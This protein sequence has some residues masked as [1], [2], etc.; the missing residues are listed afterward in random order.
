MWCVR[1]QWLLSP[2]P[3]SQGA[4]DSEGLLVARLTGQETQAEVAIF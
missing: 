2:R 3:Q 4:M 1:D